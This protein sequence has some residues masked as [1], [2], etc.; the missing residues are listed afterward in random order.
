MR[1]VRDLS[2]DVTRQQAHSEPVRVVK[3]DRV[4]DSQVKR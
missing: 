4:I 3:N 1:D 2:K